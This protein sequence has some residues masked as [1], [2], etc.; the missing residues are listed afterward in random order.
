MT[1]AQL[2][3]PSL[4]DSEQNV[5]TATFELPGFKFSKDE[6]QINVQS[7]NLTVSAET[8]KSEDSTS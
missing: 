4:K 7:R 3:T 1:I 2:S 8:R 6:V 5:V